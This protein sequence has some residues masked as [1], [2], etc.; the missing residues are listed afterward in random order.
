MA[1]TKEDLLARVEELEKEND[2][3]RKELEGANTGTPV[4][5]PIPGKIKVAVETPEGKQ[6]KGEYKFR[7]GVRRVPMEDGQLVSS[8]ALIRIATGGKA[9]KEE[10]E[11][12]PRLQGV[13]KED[14]AAR[15]E[16]WV[17]IGSTILQPA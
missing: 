3:L 15:I 5:V 16:Y 4:A 8:A 11:Q 12:Y 2:E 7:P 14:A 6:V 17:S 10:L 13:S 9:T 1:E